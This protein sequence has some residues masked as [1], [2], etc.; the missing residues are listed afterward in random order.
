VK[1]KKKMYKK[2]D[3]EAH[4]VDTWSLKFQI[5]SVTT[6]TTPFKV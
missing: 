6:Y 1:I 5:R 2:P 3:G 4:V